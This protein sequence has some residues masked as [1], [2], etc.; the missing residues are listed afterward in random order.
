MLP[1]PQLSTISIH[2]LLAESDPTTVQNIELGYI[3]IHALLAESDLAEVFKLWRESHFY[4]RSPCGERL[5]DA[6]V[7]RR[8]PIISIHALLAESDLPCPTLQ[9]YARYFYPRSPCGERRNRLNTETRSARISIHALLAESDRLCVDTHEPACRFLSTLSLRRATK[10]DGTASPTQNDFYPRSPCG[11]RPA[12]AALSPSSALISIHALLAES[13]RHWQMGHSLAR[14]FLSTLSLR[15]A[16]SSLNADSGIRVFLSTLSLRRATGGF[17]LQT[18]DKEF[19]STLSLR[20][21]TRKNPP[22][23][24]CHSNFYPRSPC[25]ERPE[26]GYRA[27]RD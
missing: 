11:E 14:Q 2:A 12:P 9:G 6:L 7:I 4:P 15:R 18:G 3:S 5:A 17:S 19:L 8:L 13:D 26:D 24:L 22:M 25:G 10:I 1:C 27:S 23:Q 16:T 21:A 20:R